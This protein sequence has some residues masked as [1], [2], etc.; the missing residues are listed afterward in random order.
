MRK[1]WHRYFMRI[2]LLVSERATCIRRQV[3][4]VLVKD[5]RILSTGY[6]GPPKGLA[7]CSV[8][9]CLRDKLGVPS[10]ER[11]EICRG[12]HA[13]QN[14][15]VQAAYFGVSING[16][17]I[18]VTHQPCITCSKLIINAG[19]KAVYYLNPYPDPLGEQIL[20]EASVPL[21]KI[22]ID[23]EDTYYFR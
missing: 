10:G 18:Y 16:G 13:E 20:S 21:I 15:I 19:L 9:G 12:I 5:K 8:V 22:D 11:Q 2:A 17:V 14:A 23:N 1:D 6:N 4:A 7:H 3:G